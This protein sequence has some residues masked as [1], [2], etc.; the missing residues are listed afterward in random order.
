MQAVIVK[1]AGE[2]LSEG[3]ILGVCHVEAAAL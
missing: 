1:G 2:H 3:V